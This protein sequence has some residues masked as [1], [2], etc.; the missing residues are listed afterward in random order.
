M[1]VEEDRRSAS[2]SRSRGRSRS[3]SDSRSRRSRSYSRSH[4][5]HSRSRSRSD[6]SRRSYGGYHGEIVRAESRDRSRSPGLIPERGERVAERAAERGS[7]GTSAPEDARAPR[8]QQEIARGKSRKDS[9]GR[10]VG[11]GSWHMRRPGHYSKEEFLAEPGHPDRVRTA[12]CRPADRA[13]RE[14]AGA[15]SDRESDWKDR[16]AIDPEEHRRLKAKENADRE[17]REH[18]RGTKRNY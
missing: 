16:T 4:S 15:D 13:E 8:W 17:L 10:R 7:R 12:D 6:D 18:R 1:H 2:R 14:A 3:R 5:A 11:F 9:E